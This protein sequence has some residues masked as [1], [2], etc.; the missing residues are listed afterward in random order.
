MKPNILMIFT[1]QMHKSAMGCRSEHVITPN[2]DRLAREGTMF[3]NAYANNPVC[4]PYRGNLFSGMY[5]RD[6]GCRLNGNPLPDCE[7]MADTFNA[8]G[9]ATSFVGK[10][11]LGDE[12]NKPI[13]Q[14]I[15]GGFRHFIG[16]Q[17]YNGF[18]DNV[19]FYDEDDQVHSYNRHRTDV[20]TDL[21]LDRLRM[22]ANAGK[23]FLHVVFYQ[24]PHYPEQPADEYYEQYRGQTMPHPPNY[25]DI[26]PYTPTFSPPSPRPFEKDP[27]YRN[28]GNNMQE[29]LR[30]YFAMVTQIDHGIGRML[31][32]LD[33]LGLAD[34]TLVLFSSDHGDMQGSHGLK[35]KCLPHEESAGIPLLLRVPREPGG[36]TVDTPVS[37]IDYYPTAV[38]YAGVDTK[39]TFSGRS[40]IPFTSER[41][42]AEPD[43]K[44]PV[45][46]ENY[47]SEQHWI[48]I[49]DGKYKLTLDL[50]TDKPWL[51]HDLEKDPYE[52]NNLVDDRM[53][54]GRFV[55]HFW[56]ASGHFRTGN[57]SGRSGYR[58]M[59]LR[60]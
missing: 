41:P 54:S 6:N 13:P 5:T 3:V 14:E 51:L 44:T 27:D 40:L 43:T 33:R 18:Y 8:A 11:H 4:G 49:R 42:A 26:D 9:Y 38:D 58:C 46:A 35:N 28:Y 36:R 53:R 39:R 7:C 22:L 16:Y 60:G 32:E 25:Q 45:F 15:R 48:M 57:R 55:T 19:N 52:S 31:A 23:P 59:S 2:L 21:G 34:D 47:Q 17:C 50:I 37:S 30:R 29:Y 10:W 12:G 1:D 24:A 56:R 20:T